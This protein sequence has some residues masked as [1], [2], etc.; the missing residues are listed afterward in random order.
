LA[1]GGEYRELRV[2][3]VLYI[4]GSGRSGSTLLANILG[5]IDGFSSV[6]EL[7]YLWE[8]GVLKNR[9][10]GCGEWFRD[11][12]FWR[13]T[14]GE[15]RGDVAHQGTRVQG[16]MDALVRTRHAAHYLRPFQSIGKVRKG[17]AELLNQLE[18]LYLAIAKHTG[19]R[20]IV[21]SS[22]Y[23]VYGRAL[24]QIES[25]DLY[26]VHLIRD[27]RAVSYSWARKKR[28][29]DKPGV[30]F[31]TRHGPV[32]S[33]MMWMTWNGLAETLW[34]GSASR[35]TRLRYEDFIAQPAVAVSQL[36][37]FLGEEAVG[38]ELG[39]GGEVDIRMSHTVSGNPMRFDSGKVLL[40]EDREWMRAMP[41][42][43]R[44]INVLL[45]WPQLLRYGYMGRRSDRASG[46]SPLWLMPPES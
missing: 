9:R 20:V 18:E 15:L 29:P 27:S 45:T 33:S 41:R 40:R 16:L 3:K 5:T 30:A 12:Q 43:D 21:D 22:K 1:Q 14:L 36:A 4:V 8:R 19:A 31:L 2:V 35:Y 44:C 37:A 38:V 26:A 39:E 11:C 32:G 34:R 7:Y 6:G 46:K 10:C 25:L 13:Q 42:I 23:P 28:Q 17:E 24:T